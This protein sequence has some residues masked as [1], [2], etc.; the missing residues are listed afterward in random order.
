MDT[1]DHSDDV[2]LYNVELRHHITVP[3]YAGSSTHVLV[4]MDAKANTYYWVTSSC[5][6][7]KEGQIYNVK[8]KCNPARGNRLSFVKKLKEEQHEQVD[9]KIKLDAEDILFPFNNK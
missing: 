2:T 5:P 1:L 8:A 3:G 7:F 6:D 4:F 9:P